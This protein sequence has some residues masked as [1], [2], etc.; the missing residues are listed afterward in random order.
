MR[1]AILQMRK[2]RPGEV[3]YP[4]QGCS[5]G[6]SHGLNRAVWPQGLSY[7]P[8]TMIRCLGFPGAQ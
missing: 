5:V 2:L 4:A 6:N 7:H 1:M 8:H 3:K